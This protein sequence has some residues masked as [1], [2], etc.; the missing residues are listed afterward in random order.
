[1]KQFTGTVL[2]AKMDKTIVVE[3]DWLWQHPVYKKRV[4]RSKKYL[5]HSDQKVE[6]G[7]TVT[8]KETRPLSKRKRWI[9]VQ[10]SK[11]QTLNPKQTQ[12]PKSKKIK[13]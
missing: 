11:P 10:N 1:M 13:N 4:K 8:F 6:L 5:V 3:V 2:K 12:N 9:L 7:Q